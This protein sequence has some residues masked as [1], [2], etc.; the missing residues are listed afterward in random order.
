MLVLSS[1]CTYR[2][3]LSSRVSIA[4]RSDGFG[5]RR[6]GEDVPQCLVSASCSACPGRCLRQVCPHHI[7]AK[8]AAHGLL[9][10]KNEYV[11]L[12]AG[13]GC[14]NQVPTVSLDIDG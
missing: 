12:L 1:C 14:L 6:F 2:S 11:H 3:P 4:A 13:G 9:S 5:C 8:Q 7:V 10:V